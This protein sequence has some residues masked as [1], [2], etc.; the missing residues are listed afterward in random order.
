MDIKATYMVSFNYADVG[1][2]KKFP[3]NCVDVGAQDFQFT[4]LNVGK[5]SRYFN[6]FSENVLAVQSAFCQ[7]KANYWN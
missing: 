2:C 6:L 3:R 1:K 4:S 5:Y 7:F